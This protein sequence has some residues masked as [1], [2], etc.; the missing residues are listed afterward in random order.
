MKVFTVVKLSSAKYGC[1]PL[2]YALISGTMMYF[3]AE[4]YRSLVANIRIHN[5]LFDRKYTHTL[6]LHKLSPESENQIKKSFY[7]TLITMVADKS[8]ESFAEL[9]GERVH[10]K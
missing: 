10:S 9:H 8:M 7:F 2:L 6:F 1:F 5:I 4:F 3:V